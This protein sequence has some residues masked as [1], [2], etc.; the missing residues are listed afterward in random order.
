LGREIS[1]PRLI[2]KYATYAVASILLANVFL[3]YFVGTSSLRVWMTESPA[4]HPMAFFVMAL[5]TALVFFDFVPGSANRPASSPALMAGY[6][7][8]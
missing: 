1:G 8:C 7:R 2:G 4:L 3:S 6:N 5:T